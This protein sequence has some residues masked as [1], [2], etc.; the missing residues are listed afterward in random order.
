[1]PFLSEIIETRHTRDEHDLFV[2][3]LSNRVEKPVYNALELRAKKLG[4]W[5]YSYRQRGAV[6]GFQFKER[7]KAEKF[8]SLEYVDGTERVE[9]RLEEKMNRASDRLLEDASSWFD[10]GDCLVDHA[11]RDEWAF[12]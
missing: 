12:C 4:G 2:V 9:E 3:Q 6:P 8:R 1:V 5:Y 10:Y 7:D 11:S